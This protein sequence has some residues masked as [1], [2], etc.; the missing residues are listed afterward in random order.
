MCHTL[1]G[2]ITK[3]EAARQAVVSR[4]TVIR[5]AEAGLISQD[6]KGRV[7]LSEL[8]AAMEAPKH[9]RKTGRRINCRPRAFRLIKA[10]Q[11]YVTAYHAALG[12]SD[13]IEEARDFDFTRR[14]YLRRA[15]LFAAEMWS[16]AQLTKK[17]AA[18]K[19]AGQ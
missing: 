9:G 13:L 8:K 7:R 1:R 16:A 10:G 19:H 11:T 15:V 17:P 5:Y 14:E 4:R 2:R 18:V 6:R 12:R 3:S